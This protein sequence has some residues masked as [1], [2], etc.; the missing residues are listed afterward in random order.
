LASAAR[1]HEI[2]II[3]CFTHIYL[4][5]HPHECTHTNKNPMFSRKKR[6]KLKLKMQGGNKGETFITE[7]KMKITRGTGA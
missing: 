4:F 1:I 5:I 2:C 3:I 7:G 6:E